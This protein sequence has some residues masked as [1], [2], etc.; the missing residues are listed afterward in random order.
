MRGARSRLDLGVG[1]QF[2]DHRKQLAERQGQGSEG[3]AQVA[4]I[5]VT[6]SAVYVLAT[7]NREE[8]LDA[9]REKEVDEIVEAA[10]GTMREIMDE[11]PS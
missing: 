5:E 3:T 1:Q 11:G 7:I 2:G 9:G 6:C 10:H 4:L 8:M